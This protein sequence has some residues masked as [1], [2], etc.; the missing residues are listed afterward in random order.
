MLATIL[1]FLSLEDEA[2]PLIPACMHNNVLTNKCWIPHLGNEGGT[3]L[4]PLNILGGEVTKT[5]VWIFSPALPRSAAHA[6]AWHRHGLAPE[7]A[8]A[9]NN[10]HLHMVSLLETFLLHHQHCIKIS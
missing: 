9:W 10:H 6:L 4:T 1:K 5:W 7:A 8:T 3:T 2:F